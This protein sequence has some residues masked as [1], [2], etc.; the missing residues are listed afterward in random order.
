MGRRAFKDQMY[1]QFARLGKAL[2]SPAR[3][4]LLDLL[5]QGERPVE[6]LA[7]EAALSVANAS[8]H[9]RVLHQACLVRQH[10]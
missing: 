6:A 2:A 7:Q 4:E 9:L 1:A 10:G 5:A 3:L 8:A